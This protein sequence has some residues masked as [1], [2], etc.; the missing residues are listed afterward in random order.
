[1]EHIKKLLSTPELELEESCYKIFE[2]NDLLMRFIKGS[3]SD[4]QFVAECKV[5]RDFY[6]DNKL[7]ITESRDYE[8][9]A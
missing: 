2:F 1:M 4:S 9:H 5:I 6:R 7:I 3:L 8:E